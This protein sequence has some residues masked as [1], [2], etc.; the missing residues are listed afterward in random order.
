MGILVSQ[1]MF[2]VLEANDMV[3]RGMIEPFQFKIPGEDPRTSKQNK[4][5][6]RL[7]KQKA[8]KLTTG[9]NSIQVGQNRPTNSVP[10]IITQTKSSGILSISTTNQ[11]QTRPQTMPKPTPQQMS[12]QGMPYQQQG[13]LQQQMS[14][15]PQMT[16]MS[17]M[18][19]M[20]PMNTMTHMSNHMNTMNPM[21][22]MNAMNA[23]NPMNPM[24]PMNQMAA[25][26][27]MHPMNPMNQM[28]TMTTMMGMNPPMGFQ[29]PQQ[30]IMQQGPGNQQPQGLMMPH[31]GQGHSQGQ[32]G[33]QGQSQQN[34]IQQQ[35]QMMNGMGQ[36][37]P[38][39][40]Q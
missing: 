24:N 10:N 5:Q 38:I 29:V 1:E 28:N 4:R 8:R 22:G 35:Q 34:M 36:G 9:A 6:D 11:I 23:M 12:Q 21:F 39:A 17:P 7:A 13:Q 26:N 18:N 40:K 30:Q 25:M 2:E 3:L 15:F 14:Q 32:Q 37:W 27:S 33:Q 19:Q 31:Q 16:Q 20:N